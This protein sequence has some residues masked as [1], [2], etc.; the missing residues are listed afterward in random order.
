MMRERES[1]KGRREV[2]EVRRVRKE[3]KIKT[4][5]TRGWM[6]SDERE[7]ERKGKIGTPLWIEREGVK[8]V[9]W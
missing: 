8:T 7:Q 2:M 3:D 9:R 4:K 1:R 6:R 5:T